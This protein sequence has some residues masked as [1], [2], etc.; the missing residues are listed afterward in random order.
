MFYS[1]HINSQDMHHI[2]LSFE[3]I[4]ACKH[5]VRTQARM[6]THTHTPSPMHA[7]TR[8]YEHAHTR[9]R[10]RTH[11]HAHAHAQDRI[12]KQKK[13]LP[14][15]RAAWIPACIERGALL[16]V[17]EF[18]L[19]GVATDI[20]QSSVSSFFKVPPHAAACSTEHAQACHA[21]MRACIFL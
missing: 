20:S 21:S 17:A 15:V 18:K 2:I 13:A 8:T 4:D 1:G 10:A 7:H 19:A 6:H 3:D 14:V 12:R 16:D 9:A 11:T 5:H